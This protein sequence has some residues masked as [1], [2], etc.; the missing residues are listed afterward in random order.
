MRVSAAA[1]LL[2]L[3]ACGSDK[4]PSADDTASTENGDDTGG[5]GDTDAADSPSVVAVLSADCTTNGDGVD[6]WTVSVTV[7][8]PQG[9]VARVGSSV[10]VID[11]ED[12]LAT[13]GLA[14]S[15]DTCSGSW[16][17]TDDDITCDVGRASV[18]RFVI[19]DE[20]GH[21]S[22]PYDHTPE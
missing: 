15:E 21:E 1:L 10:S 12:V 6:I 14:C 11:G 5:G 20:F 2:A 7:A 13:Y 19:V 22:A 16:R 18:L 4:E 17:N 9:D 3:V 8:D